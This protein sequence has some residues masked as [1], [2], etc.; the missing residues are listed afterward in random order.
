MN[1]NG[2]ATSIRELNDKLRRTGEGGQQMVTPGINDMGIAL[3]MNLRCLI[4]E[5]DDFLEDN[6]PHREHDFGSLAFRGQTVFWKI[7][8]YDKTFTAG[9]ADPSDPNVT[10]RVLTIMLAQEY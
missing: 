2:V 5:F 4:A 1:K 10:T 7:D 6:D 9:S 8:Y 3:V